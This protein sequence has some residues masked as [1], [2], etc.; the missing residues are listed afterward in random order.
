MAGYGFDGPP[1]VLEQAPDGAPKPW[2]R[3][4]VLLALWALMAALLLALVI[5]GIVE[6]SRGGGE[7]GGPAT[8]RSSTTTTPSSLTTP[9]TTPSTTIE[10]PPPPEP[11]DTPEQTPQEAPPPAN[12]SPA[13]AEPPQHQHHHPHI[14]STIP[15]PHTVITLPHG[16]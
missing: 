10:A 6:L 15:L 5:Y 9:T 1:P 8:T 7:T 13:P 2:Y 4:R 11:P 3:N 12:G 16:F 14:P